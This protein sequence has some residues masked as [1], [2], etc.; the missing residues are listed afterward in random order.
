MVRFSFVLANEGGFKV[1]EVFT[2]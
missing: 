1:F 2:F